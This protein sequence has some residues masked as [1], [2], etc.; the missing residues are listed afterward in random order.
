MKYSSD[1]SA[2][3]NRS[4]HALCLGLDK[5][6]A[7]EEGNVNERSARTGRPDAAQRPVRRIRKNPTCRHPSTVLLPPTTYL[8]APM[9][10]R[11][12]ANSNIL[13]PSDQDST[14]L[15]R[16]KS[17]PTAQGTGRQ[18]SVSK[19]DCQDIEGMKHWMLMSI[20]L[21]HLHLSN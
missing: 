6:F 4:H 12:R 9:D 2:R 21:Q 17:A 11:G 19:E 15:T 10:P 5:S 1:R 14:S 18:G 3:P 16:T 7:I 13:K 20:L 8:P